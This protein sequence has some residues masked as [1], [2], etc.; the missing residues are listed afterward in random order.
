MKFSRSVEQ[1]D[2]ARTLDALLRDSDTVAAARAWGRS[3]TGP[4]WKLWKKLADTGVTGLLVDEDLGGVGG[5]HLDVVTAF[6]RL[7]YHGAPGPWIESA[8][9]VP[10]LLVDTIETDLSTAIGEGLL[11]ASITEPGATRALDAHVAARTFVAAGTRLYE[12]TP[13]ERLRSIDP[14][15]TLFTVQAASEPLL[16]LPSI[17]AARAYDSGTLA[18]ASMLVG[19]GERLL[20]ETVAYVSS[21]KQFGRVV[22]GY[23]AV[24][25]CLAD[26]RV[27]LDFARPLIIGAAHELSDS[28]T[29][30][31]R[32][33]SAAK[34][35]ANRAAYRAA[36]AALQLH[37]AVG[38]TAELDVSMWI[39][40]VQALVTAWGTTAVHRDR[41]TT[42]L[43]ERI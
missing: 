14:V 5:T 12:G 28:S 1:D 39:L 4:G 30:S 32:D 27:A 7:G 29:Q 25:H 6:E 19:A 33:V 36:R 37:G 31:S 13:S 24:K 3:D 22:G 16:E 26:V 43:T 11:C 42:A 10:M 21:R 41:I 2:F 8:V 35:A 20:D 9:V 17:V 15:R 40:R 34:I 18:C 23:Q 38:Y